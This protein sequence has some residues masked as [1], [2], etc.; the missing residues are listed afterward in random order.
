[1][2]FTDFQQGI[3]IGDGSFQENDGIPYFIFA[4]TNRK[5]CDHVESWYKEKGI[6]YS[7]TERQYT[8]PAKENWEVLEMLVSYQMDAFKFKPSYTM[9]FVQGYLQTKGTF[10]TYED[11][12][13]SRI[14]RY[15]LSFSGPIDQLEI[16]Q[17]VLSRHGVKAVKL[18]QRKEREHLGV[19][20]RS[21]RMSFSSR[22][23]IATML[24][25][26]DDNQWLLEQTRKTAEEFRAFDKG[27]PRRIPKSTF[28]NYKYATKFM[29]KELHLLDELYTKRGGDKQIRFYGSVFNSW[30]ELYEKIKPVYDEV[31]T[32]YPIV[33]E[34]YET[35]G[36]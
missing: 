20:S 1:M 28:K 25:C 32:H 26:W 5:M 23:S 8:D 21:Y 36:Q 7:K 6:R 30:E 35:I 27:T 2:E 13:G 24:S 29:I 31:F 11:S 3:L 16:I 22:E 10:Y 17:D 9:D 15:R 19:I 33:V 18:C 12:K 34:R 4:T 14:K